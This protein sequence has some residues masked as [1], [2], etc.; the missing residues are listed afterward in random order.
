MKKM[1]IILAVAVSLM[2]CDALYDG[3]KNDG[4]LFGQIKFTEQ[5]VA[6]KI[7]IIEGQK[8]IATQGSYGYWQ[9]TGP[10]D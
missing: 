7:A 6:Y 4:N 3:C 2:S 10:I 5:G 9:F 1:I 8:F